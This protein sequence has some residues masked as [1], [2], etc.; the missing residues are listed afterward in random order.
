MNSN[1]ARKLKPVPQDETDVK[2]KLVPPGM[3]PME[4]DMYDLHRKTNH[5]LIENFDGRLASKR[6][7]SAPVFA[8]ASKR[9][10]LHGTGTL[11]KILKFLSGK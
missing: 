7:L 6:V 3:K 4:D 10:V 11:G 8:D 2:A 5:D 9:E 1:T